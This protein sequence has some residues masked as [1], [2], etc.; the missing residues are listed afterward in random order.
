MKDIRIQSC[1]TDRQYIS[2]Y[3]K[4]I[5][6]YKPLPQEELDKLFKEVKNGNK[7]A[8]DII[9]K[10]NLRFVISVAKS[11]QGYNIPL[12]DLIQEGNIGLLKSIHSYNP[13]KNVKFLSYAIW[14]IQSYILNSIKKTNKIIRISQRQYDINNRINKFVNHFKLKNERTPN[15]LEIKKA[16]N[17][18][19]LELSIY[20]SSISNIYSIEEPINDNQFI[21][22]TLRSDDAF[23]SSMD[24]EDAK[25]IVVKLL[26]FLP[27]REREIL[28][29]YYGFN[30]SP[31]STDNIA[32]KY[33][34]S[35]ERVRQIIIASINKLKYYNK[36]IA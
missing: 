25:E 18:T 7:K 4:E 8:V 14:W 36:K 26:S 21:K 3:L 16:V 17:V 9:L 30:N 23:F 20:H 27:K 29:Y 15:D 11:Y 6:K 12:S 13:E 22:D 24:R 5:S 31:L 1:I 2:S 34:I 33:N 35:K 19:D 10:S 32:E 28:K